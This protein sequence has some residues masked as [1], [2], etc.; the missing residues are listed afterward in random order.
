MNGPHS[1]LLRILLL[2]SLVLAFIAAASSALPPSPRW[3]L[4]G[5]SALVTGGTKGIGRAIVFELA[6]KGC[7]VLTC[8]RNST[9]VSALVAAADARFGKGVVRGIVA[10]AACKKGRALIVDEACKCFNSKLDI[11]VNNVGTNIRKK[12]NDYNEDEIHKIFN[13]N[14]DS[15]FH[16]SRLCH[17]LLK[18]RAA[19]DSS[20]S[21][22]SIV[23]IGS[24]A[25]QTCLPS[26]TPYAATK[27]AMHQLTRNLSC[28]WASDGIRVNAVSPWY[29]DTPLTLPVLS[30]ETFKKR[31]LE[32]TPMRRVGKP[33]EVAAAVAF[34]C[35]PAA[36][37]ITG[38]VLAVD[39]GFTNNGF[40]PP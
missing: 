39:G 11:L 25:A 5:K 32:R 40:Y 33:E 17:P 35:L 2:L 15:F 6:S 3:T 20:S 34:F 23:N 18:T 21:F 31:V 22:S 7:H 9:E 29:I 38:Q 26:G 16:L 1:S 4:N 19:T 10:D 37:Y 14:F 13:T 30:D 8:S 36:E 28:E 12:T 27:S 24:V